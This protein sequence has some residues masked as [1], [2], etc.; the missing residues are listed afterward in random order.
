M[1]NLAKKDVLKDKGYSYKIDLV[2]PTYTSSEITHVTGSIHKLKKFTLPTEFLL[3]SNKYCCIVRL[4]ILGFGINFEIK[5][6][7]IEND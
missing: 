3:I 4:S 7:S 1:L 2:H 5:T 6:R